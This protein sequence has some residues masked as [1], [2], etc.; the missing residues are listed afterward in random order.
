MRLNTF[1]KFV[2]AFYNGKLT[3]DD[4]VTKVRKGSEDPYAIIRSYAAFL[5]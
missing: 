4:I 5:Q 3:V 2:L 1:E